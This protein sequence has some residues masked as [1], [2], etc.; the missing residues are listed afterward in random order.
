MLK[1]RTALISLL[2]SGV[3]SGSQHCSH[4]QSLRAGWTDLPG[5]A[6]FRFGGGID[7]TELPSEPGG[8]LAWRAEL[9]NLPAAL[10]NDSGEHLSTFLEAFLKR[11]NEPAREANNSHK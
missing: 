10:I 11:S 9:I 8:F 4:K 3:E 1:T 6:A 5:L 2:D 7:G